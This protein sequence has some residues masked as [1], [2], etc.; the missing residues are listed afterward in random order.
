MRLVVWRYELDPAQAKMGD[1]GAH[2]IVSM[3]IGAEVLTAAA[4]HDKICVWARVNPDEQR[5]MKRIF[6]ICGTGHPALFSDYL[7]TV[8]LLDGQLVFHVF[9]RS[10]GTRSVPR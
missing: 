4:Q 5:I 1:E 10:N 8:I 3:P 2:L 6:V 7:G 9:L